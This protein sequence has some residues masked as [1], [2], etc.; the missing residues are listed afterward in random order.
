MLQTKSFASIIMLIFVV[1]NHGFSQWEAQDPGFPEGLAPAYTSVVDENIVWV[2]GGHEFT[3][4]PYS[5]FSKTIDG[6]LT[7]TTGSIVAD[8][9]QRFRFGSIFALND[10]IAWVTMVDDIT[11]FHRGKIFKTID[12]GISWVQQTSAYQDDNIYGHMPASI[13]FFDENNGFIV[14]YYGENYTTTDGGNLWTIV[15][16]ENMP[17]FI[18]IEKPMNSN[19]WTMGDSL[20]WHGTME[21]RIFKTT[22]R[23]YSW[24]AYDV[25]LGKSMVFTSFKD[26]LNGFATTPIINRK[27]AKTTDGGETWQVLDRE[28]PINAILVYL[29]GTENTYMY[30]SGDLPA[31][32]SSVPGYGFTMDE[33]NT[34]LLEDDL[35]LDPLYTANS[36]TGWA[37]GST[38]DK[39][40]YKWTGQ[41]LDSLGSTVGIKELRKDNT[42]VRF[43]L[44]QNYPNPFN[45]RTTIDYQ[46]AENFKVSLIIYDIT[47]KEIKTLVN[48]NQNA[49]KYSVPLYANDLSTGIYFYKLN[50]EGVEQSRKMLVYH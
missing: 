9:L 20:A 35:P 17:E 37:V 28:L 43:F 23:G 46:L 12:G 24:K 18:G 41:N 3:K 14:G 11:L 25:G 40:I 42:P 33:G 31:A 2:L 16:D 44:S 1:I 47:G 39:N 6:G 49:G 26:E 38:Y 48:T 29:E 36:S 45:Q 32:I 19:F 13:H 27:I 5:G 50:I 34:W 4:T 8:D 22:D 15:P 10:R 7:W 30:G 21:G